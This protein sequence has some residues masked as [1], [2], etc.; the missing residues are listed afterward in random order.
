M[1]GQNHE[2]QNG[3]GSASK[4]LPFRTR[5]RLLSI[6]RLPIFQEVLQKIGLSR[7]LS[8]FRL[9][10]IESELDPVALIPN[11]L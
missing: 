6:G 5:R 4:M 8:E 3:H 7:K 10:M 1:A 9:N 11:F 2:L